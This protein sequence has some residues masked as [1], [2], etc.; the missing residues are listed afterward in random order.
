MTQRW[1]RLVEELPALNISILRRAGAL[2]AARAIQTEGVRL[3]V[4]VWPDRNWP[5]VER[6][7]LSLGGVPFCALPL[8]RTRC[9]Y[10]GDRPWFL[11]S[12]CGRRAGKLYILIREGVVSCRRCAHLGYPSENESHR[13]RLRRKARK[14]KTRLRWQEW[15][16]VPQKPP[17]MHWKTYSDLVHA[18]ASTNSIVSLLDRTW[19]F[20]SVPFSRLPQGF[21]H[22]G[23]LLPRTPADWSQFLKARRRGKRTERARQALAAREAWAEA[24]PSWFEGDPTKCH[25]EDAR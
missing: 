23:A 16:D 8:T 4:E 19:G 11:C 18:A 5:G 7:M 24:D 17:W 12:V 9:N 20:R 14:I 21:R 6:L 22:L 15:E 3:D 2:Q 25:A 13:D 10:G 1:R